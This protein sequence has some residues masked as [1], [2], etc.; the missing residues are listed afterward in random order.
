MQESLAEKEIT[1]EIIRQGKRVTI[2]AIQH[3]KLSFEIYAPDIIRSLTFPEWLGVRWGM[4]F[5][6]SL[7]NKPFFLKDTS[8]G[9]GYRPFYLGVS[10]LKGT[11]DFLWPPVMVFEPGINEP[12]DDFR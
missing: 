12:V 2:P 7:F 5:M 8:G 11:D 3:P 1:T 4:P 9:T 6:V 10:F